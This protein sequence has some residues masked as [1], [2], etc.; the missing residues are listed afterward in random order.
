MDHATIGLRVIEW[1]EG[2]GLDLD[3]VRD[4]WRAVVYAVMSLLVI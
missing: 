3:Q 4:K 1:E 2:H